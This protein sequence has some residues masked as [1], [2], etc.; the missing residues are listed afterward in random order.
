MKTSD[1]LQQ[2]LKKIHVPV[3]G[4]S[5]SRV[6]GNDRMAVVTVRQQKKSGDELFI[7]VPM[8]ALGG[9]FTAREYVELSVAEEA[10]KLLWVLVK[11]VPSRTCG[12]LGKDTRGRLRYRRSSLSGLAVLTSRLPQSYFSVAANMRLEDVE[13]ESG[14]KVLIIEIGEALQGQGDQKDKPEEEGGETGPR[15]ES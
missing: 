4:T 2:P 6:A 14:V 1:L 8:A 12:T 10:G 5:R 3:A 9:A 15:S 13:G 11:A 7:S